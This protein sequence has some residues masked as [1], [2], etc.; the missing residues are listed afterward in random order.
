MVGGLGRGWGGWGEVFL[1]MW[2]ESCQIVAGLLS[3]VAGGL[4]IR[5]SM[6]VAGGGGGGA[7]GEAVGSAMAEGFA[8][9][10][11]RCMGCRFGACD[12]V[13]LWLWGGRLLKPLTIT[14]FVVLGMVVGFFAVPAQASPADVAADGTGLM[15]GRG[16]AR[17]LG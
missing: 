5:C 1:F 12:G 4:A 16:L 14:V 10:L 13:A 3:V 11:G 7:V 6:L 2:V 15:I 17:C 8:G 9:C